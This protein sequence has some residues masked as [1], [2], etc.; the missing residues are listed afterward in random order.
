MMLSNTTVIWRGLTFNGRRGGGFTLSSL[1][2]WEELPPARRDADPRPQGHGRFD[3][4]VFSDE[5]TVTITGS[6]FSAAERDARLD[7]LGHVMGFRTGGAEP[8]IVTHAGLTLTAYAKLTRYKPTIGDGWAAGHFPFA[9]EWV[10]SDPLRYA[11][12]VTLTTGYPAPAGGLEY[13]LYTDGAGVDLGFLEYGAPSPTGRLLLVNPGTADVSPVFKITG[14]VV[15]GFELIR[16]GKGDRLRYV[17]DIPAGSTVTL[18]SADATVLMDAL[19]DRAGNL[20]IRDWWAIGAESSVEVTF[21][22]TGSFSA[23]S[24]AVTFS[25]GWW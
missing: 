4:E 11:A 12:P 8:L 3:A 17:G 13:D 24:L 18:D 25:P 19:Y 7:A 2:G 10:C 23:A 15:G 9:V 22:P 20:T 6:C 5:R 21:V 14:P 1:E 16:T